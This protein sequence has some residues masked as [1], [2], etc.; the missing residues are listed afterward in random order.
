M[1]RV[2]AGA[3]V[4]LLICLSPLVPWAPKVLKT[5]TFYADVEVQQQDGAGLKRDTAYRWSSNV[6]DTKEYALSYI[7]APTLI[8]ATGT[9]LVGAVRRERSASFMALILVTGVLPVLLM[10]SILSRYLLGFSLPIYVLAAAAIGLLWQT[11]QSQLSRLWVRP[12]MRIATQGIIG[13]VMIAVLWP[14]L[15]LTQTM[16]T[17]PPEPSYRPEIGGA[18]SSIAGA[19]TDSASMSH[20]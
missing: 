8:L 3:I 13:A 15:A 18:T 9:M 4:A 12:A 6:A 16:L 5:A 20:F 1:P 11:L 19:C 10:T 2:M 7:G 14:Q 17:D